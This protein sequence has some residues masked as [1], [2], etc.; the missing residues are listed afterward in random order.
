MA[1]LS[2]PLAQYRLM[3]MPGHET[4]SP[5]CNDPANLQTLL[6]FPA[7]HF[8]QSRHPPVLHRVKEQKAIKP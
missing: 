3:V 5:G 1:I 6:G 4:D 8:Q 2:N 7:L